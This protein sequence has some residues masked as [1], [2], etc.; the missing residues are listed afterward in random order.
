MRTGILGLLVA[1]LATPACLPP[2][3][4]H[5][6]LPHHRPPPGEPPPPAVHHAPAPARHAGELEGPGWT[7]IGHR[8]V[9]LRADHDLIKVGSNRGRFRAIGFIFDGAPVTMHRVLVVFGNGEPFEP[10]VRQRFAPGSRTRRIDLPGN[11]RNIRRVEFFY[12]SEDPAGGRAMMELRGQLAGGE[13]PPP[14]PPGPRTAAPPAP[15]PPAEP[16]AM[17]PAGELVN[18]LGDRGWVHLGER[19]VS[20][21]T[22][23]DVIRVGPQRGKWRAIAFVVDGNVVELERV[24][25]VFGNKKRW[26]PRVRHAFKPGTQTRRINIPKKAR[27]IRAVEFFYRTAHKGPGAMVHLFGLPKKR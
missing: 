15:P 12:N 26:D 4:P 10:R 8:K 2:P 1:A 11:A 20:R 16:V 24:S 6:P 9:N 21:R 7:T 5:E 13:P 14:P 3:P 22:E 18:R 19:R 25:V 27:Q 17:S 23:R